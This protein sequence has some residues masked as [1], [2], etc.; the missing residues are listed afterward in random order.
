M[1]LFG[2]EN[3]FRAVDCTVSDVVNTIRCKSSLFCVFLIYKI[4]PRLNCSWI[5]VLRLIFDG[6]N[7]IVDVHADVHTVA[8]ATSM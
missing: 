6:S 3:F 8:M 1:L 2:I 5:V 4:K 7:R